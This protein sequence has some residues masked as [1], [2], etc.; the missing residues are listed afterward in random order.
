MNED[1]R[2]HTKAD[3][4]E[5]L[6]NKARNMRIAPTETEKL[7]WLYLRDGKLKSYKFRRQHSLGQFIV[8]FYC[9]KA[10]LII[11]VDGPIHEFQKEA[12]SARQEYL[13]NHEFRVIRF[14]NDIVV[15]NIGKVVGQI[16]SY[17]NSK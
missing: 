14:S 8:D 5:K 4:W 1:D 3:L 9:K 12:D 13:E 16:T 11:E 6:K 2:W 17:L 15:N 7:L 10:K